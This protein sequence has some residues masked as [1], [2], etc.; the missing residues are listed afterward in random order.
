DQILRREAQHE[1]VK[2]ARFQIDQH[3]LVAIPSD[4]RQPIEQELREPHHRPAPVVEPALDRT[5]INP[6]LDRCSDDR[7]DLVF[8]YLPAEP[9]TFSTYATRRS[10]CSVE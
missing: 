8:H 7:N 3:G 1:E 10:I 6:L 5:G 2:A 9:D 4:P